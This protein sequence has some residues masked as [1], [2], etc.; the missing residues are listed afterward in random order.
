MKRRVFTI[1]SGVSLV[2]CL[3]TAGLWAWSYSGRYGFYEWW[4]FPCWFPC[5][6]TV[7]LPAIWLWRYRRDRRMPTDGMPHCATCDYNL[8]GNV[9]GICPECGTPIPADLVR[10]P[11]T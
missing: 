2:L 8:T 6:L 4:A 5:T 1:L 3:A 10:R 9:S 11:M 7:I